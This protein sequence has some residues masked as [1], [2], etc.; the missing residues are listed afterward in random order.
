M[1]NKPLEINLILEKAYTKDESGKVIEAKVNGQQAYNRSDY[2]G[3][4]SLLKRFDTRM[5][6]PKDWK[7][8]TK[9]SEKISNAFL[10]DQKKIELSLDETVFLRDY[11]RSLI[12]KNSLAG[13]EKEKV[14]FADHEVKTLIGIS[15]QLENIENAED[16]KDLD[17]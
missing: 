2:G 7:T 14:A 15:D 13:K 6:T 3:L 9:I 5:N 8:W 12:E 16:L 10:H 1:K 4:Q 11:L 17:K